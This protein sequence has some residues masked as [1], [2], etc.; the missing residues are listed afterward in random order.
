[1]DGMHMSERKQDAMNESMLKALM[2]E[3]EDENQIQREIHRSQQSH[4]TF[5][6][7]AKRIVSDARTTQT[8]LTVA[9]GV[10]NNIGVNITPKQKEHNP[11]RHVGKGAQKIPIRT[12]KVRRVKRQSRAPLRTRYRPAVGNEQPKMSPRRINP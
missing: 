9:N 7:L 2:D 5:E 6:T 12:R 3:Q 11:L 4:S 8:H 10:L 1:M